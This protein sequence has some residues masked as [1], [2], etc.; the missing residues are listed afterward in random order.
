MRHPLRSF[1]RYA[2]GLTLVAVLATCAVSCGASTNEKAPDGSGGSGA[3]DGAG[4][5]RAGSPPGGTA[6]AGVGGTA[7]T[8]A[9]G[10]AGTSAGGGS[11]GQGGASGSGGSAGQGGASGS[12]G[13]AG[14]G[15]CGGQTCGATQYCVIPC[16]GGAPPS[17]FP[18]PGSGSCPAGSHSGCTS[19]SG[20]QCS[21]PMTCCQSDPC[22]PPPPYCVD[23]LPIG[24]SL[25]EGR[26]C[27]MGCA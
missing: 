17:C 2:C 1:A 21:P 22:T 5:S 4:G 12:G 20:S 16:C 24:C 26:T 6:G 10:S 13:S 18:V 15:S 3:G 9:G 14:N 19:F 27:R 8:S 7:G 23:T 25:L 11:A